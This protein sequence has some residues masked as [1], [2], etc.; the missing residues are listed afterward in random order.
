MQSRTCKRFEEV[1]Y[2]IIVNTVY[3]NYCRIW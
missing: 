2:I 1:P 3:Y